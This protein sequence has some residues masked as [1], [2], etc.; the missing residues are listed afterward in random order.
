MFLRLQTQWRV[1]DG[2]FLGLI[3]DSVF[4]LIDLESIDDKRGMFADIQTMEFSAIP[5]INEKRDK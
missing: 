1:S 4:R 5:V 3:Y 2:C